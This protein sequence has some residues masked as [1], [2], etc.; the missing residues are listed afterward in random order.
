[1]NVKE[2]YEF[3]VQK[4][5]DVDP[6]GREAVEE[7][8]AEVQAEYEEL[9]DEQKE[10]F[11]EERLRNPFGDTRIVC[12]DL[13]AEVRRILVGIDMGGEEA[14]LAEALGR[15]GKPI[16][17]IVGHHAT[18]L[19]RPLSD[20]MDYMWVQVHMM[21]QVGVPVHVAEKVI[22]ADI[23]PK[24]RGENYR[25]A[26][27]AQLLG[28]PLVGIHTP[29]DNYCYHHVTGAVQREK[30][31]RVKD[32]VE[33]LKGIPEF[34]DGLKLG[35]APRAMIGGPKDSLGTIY[36]CLTGGYNPSPPAFESIAKAGTGTSVMVAA[37]DEHKKVASEHHM[38]I[39]IAPHY[40]ADNLGLNL[41]LDDLQEKGEFDVVSCSNFMRVERREG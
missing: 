15:Q 23:E 6:R 32:L 13:E 27:F 35:I 39:I 30:P 1:M 38:N 21:T 36:Y 2:F 25:T 37:S 14:L 7:L 24:G 34:Q 41:L 17:L 12:G 20:A 8:R 19:G 33:L 3:A 28:F 18:V 5:L 16:D 4:G 29:S 10:L 9:S 40:P 31:E 11:D 26:Q 22:R